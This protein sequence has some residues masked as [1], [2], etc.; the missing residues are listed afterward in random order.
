[1]KGGQPARAA[2][3]EAP[4]P[5]ATIDPIGAKPITATASGGSRSVNLP[6]LTATSGGP[7]HYERE[8]DAKTMAS[9]YAAAKKRG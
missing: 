1:V 2:Q 3:P 6:F 4:K 8:L 7:M 9:L 5:A